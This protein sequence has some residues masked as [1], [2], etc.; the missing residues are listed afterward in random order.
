MDAVIIAAVGD[1]DAAFERKPWQGFSDNL[2]IKRHI[3]PL[4]SRGDIRT[5]SA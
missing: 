5:G 4:K 1:I 3:T 2:S